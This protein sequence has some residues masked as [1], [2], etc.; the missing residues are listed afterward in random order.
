MPLPADNLAKS[1]LVASYMILVLTEPI[2]MCKH[3]NLDGDCEKLAR[4]ARRPLPPWPPSSIE[5]AAACC[6]LLLSAAACCFSRTLTAYS[7]SHMTSLCQAVGSLTSSRFLLTGNGPFS[8]NAWCRRAQP[9]RGAVCRQWSQWQPQACKP[10]LRQ[11]PRRAPLYRV[12][13]TQCVIP[14]Q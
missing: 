13:S 8:V 9:W 2:R 10:K 1:C 3:H 7:T 6:C 11:L 14:Q 5:S 12:N 4:L